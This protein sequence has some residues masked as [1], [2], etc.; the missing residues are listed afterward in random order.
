MLTFILSALTVAILIGA[1]IIAGFAVVRSQIRA[2]FKRID[3]Y[4]NNQ[5]MNSEY[6]DSKPQD[7]MKPTLVVEKDR[8]VLILNTVN[9]ND[10]TDKINN[11]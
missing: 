4:R 8:R 9:K 5:Y 2:T 11:Q 1:P 6:M 10:G 7:Y 3:E